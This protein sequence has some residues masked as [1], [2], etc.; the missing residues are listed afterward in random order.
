MVNVIQQATGI[1]A[2]VPAPEFVRVLR[3]IGASHIAIVTCFETELR[4]LERV[5]FH[6]NGIE[7]VRFVSTATFFI[8]PELQRE[9]ERFI[10][11]P[12]LNMVQVLLWS[13]LGWLGEPT[14]GLYISKFLP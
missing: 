14:D 4:M 11:V 13:T 5:F 1:P 12:V 8:S 9:L 7:V 10:K 6:N 3:L 2:I